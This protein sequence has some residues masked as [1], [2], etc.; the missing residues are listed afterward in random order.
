LFAFHQILNE[1]LYTDFTANAFL[2]TVIVFDLAFFFTE[3]GDLRL[4]LDI[5]T[6]WCDQIASLASD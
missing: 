6:R 4:N 2:F 1:I 5:L 3:S